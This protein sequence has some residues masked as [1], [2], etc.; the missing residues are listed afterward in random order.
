MVKMNFQFFDSGIEQK[1][2]SYKMKKFLK[3]IFFVFIIYFLPFCGKSFFLFSQN[4]SQYIQIRD[5]I[6]FSL[7]PSGSF[8]VPEGKTWRI[9]RVMVNDGGVYNMTCCSSLK[10][11]VYKGGEKI[12]AP[13]YSAESSL[14][15]EDM[16]KMKYVFEIKNIRKDEKDK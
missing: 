6:T 13:T 1:T 2:K 4:P 5:T 9:I 11:K 7:N 8:M 14:L 10:G 15:N 16:T 12:Y 3:K